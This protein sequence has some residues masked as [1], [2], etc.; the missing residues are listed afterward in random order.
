MT[1][2]A[3]TVEGISKRFGK[4]YALSDVGFDVAE[5]E[6]VVIVADLDRAALDDEAEMRRHLAV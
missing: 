5:G 2:S 3:L 1:L 6:L 4:T